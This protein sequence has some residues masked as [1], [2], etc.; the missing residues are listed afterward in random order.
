VRFSWWRARNYDYLR[1]YVPKG[2]QFISARGGDVEPKL[3]AI[4]YNAFPYEV[5]SDI[6]ALV[7]DQFFRLTPSAPV[8]VFEEGGKNV[9]ATWM[10]VDAGAEEKFTLTYRLPFETGFSSPSYTLWVEKQ[11]GIDSEFLH[12]ITLPKGAKLKKGKVETKQMLEKSFREAIAFQFPPPG[13]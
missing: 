7:A 6:G 8:E 4:N 1:I 2:A 3:K 9:F 12:S 11:S 5:D 13:E 10:I